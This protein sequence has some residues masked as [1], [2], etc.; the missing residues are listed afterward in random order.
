MSDAPK[1]LT[2]VCSCEDTMPLDGARLAR[3]CAARGSELRPAEQLCRSQLPRFL[4]ALGEADISVACTQESPLFR[5]EAEEAGHRG[6]LDFLNIRETAGWS[7]E[8]AQAGPKMAALLAAAAVPMPPTPLLPL[9]SRGVTLVLGRDATALEAAAALAE[10]L[11]L[12]V[13]LTGEEAVQ[14]PRQASFPVLRGRA[15]GATGWLGSFAVAVD[16]VAA[17]APSSRASYRWGPGKDGTT[18]RCDVILDLSGAAPLFPAHE[19]RLGY[20]RAD[21][22]DPAAV[23]RAVAQA[24]ELVGQFD[25]PRFV[26][27]DPALCAHARNRRTGCTRCLDLCPTGAITPGKESVVVS[28]EIC[29]GCGSCAAVCPTA[30]ITYALPP[31]DAILRR[32]RTLLLA[33]AEAGG[34]APVLLLHDGTHGEPILDALARHGD[35]LPARVL[36]LRAEPGALDLG[37]LLAPLAWGAEAVRVLLPARRR[38]GTDGLLR[39]LDYAAAILAGLGIEGAAPRAAALET[40]DPFAL[41]EALRALPAMPP[42]VPPASFLPQGTPREIARAALGALHPAAV[43]EA[44]APARPG[45]LAALGIGAAPVAPAPA[46]PEIL[47][48]PE[49]APF[50]LARVAAEGCT[51]CLACT[52][53]CPTG[54]LAA[55][56]DTPQLSF[57]EDACVQCGL[58]AKTCPESVITL[59]PRLNFSPEAS[60]RVVVKEEEPVHCTRCAKPFGT[61]ASVER[62]KNKLRAHWMFADPARLA[63]LDLCENCRVFAATDGGIDPYAGATRPAPR[64]AA[65]YH[66]AADTPGEPRGRG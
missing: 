44:A 23:A 20:L 10:K 22:A 3:A 65:D 50:G 35:G 60:R 36:P 12:T 30:S 32:A 2:F 33:Y 27:Q 7:D 57:L 46:P 13:L 48:L 29:A 17:A 9:E 14:P 34:A 42:A 37:A 56:P 31:A 28:A 41:G 43:P 66:G 1:R 18:S 15:R 21:P 47:P 49:L 24:G 8:A 25:K 6:A 53:V 51:L 4:A 16:R 38:H 19:V 58:C 39:N 62:V 64:T 55:N 26:Q 5:Q 54:A 11:D 63:V 45:L 61:R 40:D 52:T 59:E